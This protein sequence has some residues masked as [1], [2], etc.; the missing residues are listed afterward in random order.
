MSKSTAELEDPLFNVV[1]E[2]CEGVF[3]PEFKS[4]VWWRAKKRMDSGY[5]DALWVSGEKHGCISPE[6]NPDAPY[7]VVGYN[8]YCEDYNIP[9]DTFVKAVSLYKKF[10]DEGN[11]VII[12]GVSRAVERRLDSF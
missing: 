11:D 5:L 2:D 4:P 3:T 10:K 1:C 9:C 7:R 6:A 12:C 8:S